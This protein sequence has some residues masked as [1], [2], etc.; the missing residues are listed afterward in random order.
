MCLWLFA[1][2]LLRTIAVCGDRSG[3]SQ[4]EKVLRGNHLYRSFD[5]PSD[6]DG[7]TNL[8]DRSVLLNSRKSEIYISKRVFA[9]QAIIDDGV[10]DEN[11]H[12][13]VLTRCYFVRCQNMNGLG[14]AIFLQG[15]NFSCSESKFR[16]NSALSGGAIWISEAK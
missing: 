3:V 2:L 4:I 12:R 11:S 7:W 5:A 13:L 10:T 6:N 9:N 15:V 8:L 1:A 14:G 16:Q